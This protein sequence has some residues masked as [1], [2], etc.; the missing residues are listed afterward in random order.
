MMHARLPLLLA[1]TAVLALSLT[2]CEQ[3]NP[4]ATVFSGTTSQWRQA[5]CW[6][7]EGESIDANAC[8]QEVIQKAAA[9]GQLASIPVVPGQTVGISVDPVV[10]DAGWSP[11]I[12][13]Q[14]LTQSPITST[15]FRFTFP[16]FQEVAADGL[17]MELVAGQADATRGVWLFQLVPA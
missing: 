8:A 2:A 13:G 12:N 5:A 16:E 10:A 7:G 6:A 4:G 17:M 1:G 14:N 15:Y 3:P 9:G 11:R